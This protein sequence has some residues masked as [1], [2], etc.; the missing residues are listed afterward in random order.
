[1]NY[2]LLWLKRSLL[3]IICFYFFFEFS[4]N[5]ELIITKGSLLNEFPDVAVHR[6]V[7]VR[8]KR[9]IV[10]RKT[11]IFAYVSA[12]LC[13]TLFE[14]NKLNVPCIGWFKFL[15]KMF[16]RLKGKTLHLVYQMRKKEKEEEN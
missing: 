1:M 2:L 16:F 6:E 12:K 3:K 14:I 15:Y 7:N 9:I 10:D 8:H 5:H 11:L 4:T 13:Q